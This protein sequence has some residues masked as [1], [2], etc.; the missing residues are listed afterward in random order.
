MALLAHSINFINEDNRRSL[1]P[2][3]LEEVTDTGGTNTNEHF[4]EV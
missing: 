2:G 1:L 4:N 3:L